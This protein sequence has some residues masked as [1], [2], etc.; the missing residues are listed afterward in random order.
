MS[1]LYEQLGADRFQ[2]FV[3]ALLIDDFPDLKCFPVGQPDGGRDGLSATGG[4]QGIGETVLQVKFRREDE[5]VTAEWMISTLEGELP[6]I[7]RL[8]MRGAK[9]Y[10]LATNAKTTAHLDVGRHDLVQKWLKANVSIPAEIF[11]RDEIDRRLDARP[12]LKL[13]YPALMTGNDALTLILEA[14]AKPGRE[15]IA[16]TIRSFVSEQYLKDEQVK[17]RQVDLTSS[18]IDLFV[19]VPI[20]LSDLEMPQPVEDLG[21]F[22]DLITDLASERLASDGDEI[23]SSFNSR[24]AFLAKTAD[25]L[26]DQRTHRV[27]PWVVLQGAPGQG[28]S[29]LAQYICQVHRA[30]LLGKQDLVDALP[31]AHAGCAI[32]LPV[33]VDL[34]DFAAYLDGQRYL[35]SPNPDIETTRSLERFLASLVSIQSGGREFSI[36]DLVQTIGRSPLLLFLDGLDEVADVRLR[37]TV[38]ESIVHGLNRLQDDAID[39]QVVVTTRPS[40]VGRK[41]ALG[42]SFA[43]FNLAPI[44]RS[45]IRQY[46]EKWMIARSLDDDR[47]S[48][49]RSILDQKL[50]QPHIRELTR[51]PM[52]LAILLNL[53]LSIGHSLPDARTSLY[54]EYVKLFMT[55]EA[56]KSAVVRRHRA[57]ISGIVEHL[58]WV[59]QSGAE[60]D[61]GSGSIDEESLK[62]EVESYLDRAE[63]D[64]SVVDEVFTHGIERVWVLVQRVEGYF[65]FEVQPL[66][67][68]FAARHL[69]SSAPVLDYRHQNFGGD[70]SERF[71][72]IA[73]NPYWANVTRFYAG[74]YQP[75]EIAALHSSLKQ[76]GNSASL[77]L[78]LIA[79]NVAVELLADWVFNLKRPVQ[80]EVLDFA[81]DEMGMRLAALEFGTYDELALP[82]EC[83]RE[84]LAQSIVDHVTSEPHT[85]SSVGLARTLKLNPSPEHHLNCERW[86]GESRGGERTARLVFA[87]RAGLL[88]DG[89]RTLGLVTS[90]AADHSERRTRARAICFLGRGLMEMSVDLRNFI[91][92]EVLA[93]GG[94][95]TP[96]RS[97]ETD[98]A[99]ALAADV[100]LPRFSLRRSADPIEYRQPKIEEFL[101]YYWDEY[102]WREPRAIDSESYTMLLE[103]A[104]EAFGD[105]WAVLR[106]AAINCGGVDVWRAKEA[107]DFALDPSRPL[108]ERARLARGYQGSASWWSE[109]I[110]DSKPEMNLFWLTILLCWAPARHVQS[111][112]QGIQ[113]AISELAVDDRLRLFDAI[114]QATD[115]R[116]RRGARDRVAVV[117]SDVNDEATGVALVLAFGRVQIEEL[118]DHVLATSGV[119]KQVD[120]LNREEEW[121]SFSGWRNLSANDADKWLESLRLHGWPRGVRSRKLLEQMDWPGHVAESI[122]SNPDDYPPSLVRSVY[123]YALGQHV[124][125]PVG[126]VARRQS[127]VLG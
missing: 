40:L 115:V 97:M 44:D 113:H 51:N 91:L 23:E 15:R 99:E 29:T 50:D 45:T 111:N 17:F 9:R 32:R 77:A 120:V 68:Y 123:Q 88:Q 98:V 100:S 2:Q 122:V 93:G 106:L 3:Q 81:F 105:R 121:S 82:Q 53:I 34:R 96:Q 117:A 62:H 4:P 109:L 8:I 36:D 102:S 73:S 127:W 94:F 116:A 79:R 10:I 47:S 12:N 35:N 26:L 101:S 57:V 108:F 87:L 54:S 67:E 31:D 39:I 104:R 11:W 119:A 84:R 125:E 16:R 74:F 59:L 83:G 64:S 107:S 65:E 58:A 110:Q 42:R 56:E 5:P 46:T 37:K 124:P 49:V 52:Q 14:N 6:K 25:L 89:G 1:Y 80:N 95:H 38:I 18:L 118:P 76:L 70:R 114:R 78:Q 90:D 33:K 86:I 28:K 112:L 75:G 63:H 72:A 41:P 30:R 24:R 22:R 92:E 19:D 13:S 27:F 61:R 20:D 85:N 55:R 126:E 43:R 60:S 48:E 66:R 69:Y 7:E 103:H 71:E 21:P